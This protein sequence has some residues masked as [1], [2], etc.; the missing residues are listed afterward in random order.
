MTDNLLTGANIRLRALEPLDVDLLYEWENDTSIWKVSNTLTPFSRFQ[1][2]E[3][4]M[5]TQQDIFAS[6]QL[7]LMIEWIRPGETNIPVG[8]I[9]LFDFDPFHLR[10]GIG[11]LIRDEFREQ[12]FAREALGV[13]ILYA[14]STLQLHQ[15]YCNIS[16]GNS[17]S[18]KLFEKL[19]FVRCGIKTDWLN[20]G[21]SWKDEWMFQLINTNE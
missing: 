13:L 1:L 12:G 19:G 4:V 14:F 10:A 6:R 11:I 21:E 17:V 16:P 9:D 18:L 8:T 20:E 5:N 15:L 3:Y 7:R 2:E